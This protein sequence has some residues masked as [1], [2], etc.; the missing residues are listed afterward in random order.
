MNGP[1]GVDATK[2]L[3]TKTGCRLDWDYGLQFADPQDVPSRPEPPWSTVVTCSSTP[4]SLAS[5]PSLS[6]LLEV[7]DLSPDKQLALEFL[8][9]GLFLGP[10][11]S[12]RCPILPMKRLRDLE[13]KQCVHGPPGRGRA[14]FLNR[15][16]LFWSHQTLLSPWG[17]MCLLA[18]AEQPLD[19]S[20]ESA[21]TSACSFTARG[22][23]YRGRGHPCP[24]PRPAIW[25]GSGS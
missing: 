14:A 18:Q 21:E 11:T 9:Q 10:P 13:A 8:S 23:R 7:L 20:Q 6:Y 5:S 2:T 19:R 16:G 24:V 15:C 4:P 1:G 17:R 12:D 25:T 22:N 3:F